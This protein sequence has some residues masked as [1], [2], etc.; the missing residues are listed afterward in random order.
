MANHQPNA[1]PS[2]DGR[3]SAA[4]LFEGDRLHRKQVKFVAELAMF[5]IA[6]FSRWEALE[7]F[8]PFQK[9]RVG[10]EEG[11]HQSPNELKGLRL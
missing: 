3:P 5:T 8:P 7:C 1:A 4:V 9:Q 10:L 6:L 2:S 11:K